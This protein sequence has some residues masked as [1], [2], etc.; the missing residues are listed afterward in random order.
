MTP[1]RPTVL[2]YGQLMA[3]EKADWDETYR[4]VSALGDEL[5]PP[6]LAATIEVIASG[7]AVPNALI[8]A[9]PALRLVACFSTGYT[10]IDLAHLQARGVTLTSAA[11]VNAHDVA[12]HA[13][14]LLLSLWHG[15]PEAD[16]RV[17]DGEWRGSRAPRRSLR[18]K[19]AGIVGLGRIGNAIA[20]RLSALEMDVRWW[21]PHPKPE[22]RFARG[23]S[24]LELAGWSHVLVVASRAAPE[25]RHQIDAPVLAALGPDA[26]L[27]N[28]SRGFLVDEDA[29]LA[30]LTSGAVGGAALDV[31]E[32]EPVS[33]ARWNGVP[34]TVLTP[35]IAGFTREAGVDL[36]H[37]QHENVRRHFAGE[38]LLTP[39]HDPL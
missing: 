15:V 16:R 24:L 2:L 4:V 11:G 22:A 10:G 31:F 6:E 38:P 7:D 29:L 39:V 33:P 3:G 35:H 34:G 27:V 14:A 8:D 32:Q 28:V 19:H 26:V 13:L 12:D 5:P 37:Q 1:A 30:A 23:A 9:L 25:N 17:R 20:E 21:G 18:H 36:R